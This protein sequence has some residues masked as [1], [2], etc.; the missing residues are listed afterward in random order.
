MISQNYTHFGVLGSK[1]FDREPRS[2]VSTELTCLLWLCCLPPLL[3]QPLLHWT[4]VLV[5]CQQGLM[6]KSQKVQTLWAKRAVCTVDR[7]G[8]IILLIS[9]KW[10]KNISVQLQRYTQWKKCAASK[11]NL[12]LLMCKIRKI[13]FATILVSHCTEHTVEFQ[14]PPS[15]WVK[16]ENMSRLCCFYGSCNWLSTSVSSSY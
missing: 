9:F 15:I 2:R 1:S 5:S 10:P 6:P 4:P 11:Q 3:G 7:V 12:T 16:N 8:K 13:P 14:G